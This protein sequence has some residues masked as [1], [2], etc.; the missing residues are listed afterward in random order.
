MLCKKLE[1]HCDLHSVVIRGDVKV[2]KKLTSMYNEIDS[3]IADF[4]GDRSV[5]NNIAHFYCIF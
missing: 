1:K 4:E 2:D 5:K 3:M